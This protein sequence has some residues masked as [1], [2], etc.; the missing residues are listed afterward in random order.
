MTDK[1]H[2]S[3]H[4]S[5]PARNIPPLSDMTL[6]DIPPRIGLFPLRGTILLPKGQLPL[7]IFEP[8]YLALL[9][10]SLAHH[11]MIGIIQPS[12]SANYG[13]ET[14]PLELIGTLGRI[15]SF[16]EQE[17]G[18]F[19]ITLTGVCRF[20]LLR[21]TLTEN[22]WREGMIN[23]TPFTQDLFEAPDC[24]IDRQKLSSALQQYS[25]E[26]KL[27]LK[28]EAIKK[29]DNATLLTMLPMLLPFSADKKQILLE[30]HEADERALRLL[31]Y[32]SE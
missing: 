2:T 26:H 25:Q 20:R 9:E 28:W 27:S 31:E 18:Q 32:L 24:A 13:E 19:F 11:R 30:C 6:A 1:A 29:L 15:T 4:P 7:T 3:S 16:L 22:G 5:R 8:R 10:H 17:N 12:P 23:A 14:P 21:D